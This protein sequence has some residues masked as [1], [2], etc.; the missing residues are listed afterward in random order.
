VN[1]ELKVLA[2]D[3]AVSFSEIMR[4]L[5][6]RLPHNSAKDTEAHHL[7]MLG[8]I[9]LCGLRLARELRARKDAH[10]YIWPLHGERFDS[11]LHVHVDDAEGGSRAERGRAREEA[12]EIIMF[13]LMC[14]VRVSRDG[15][16]SKM[17]TM[18]P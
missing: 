2:R 18:R 6:H 3:L 15:E 4:P 10:E 16:G 11:E 9:V 1:A 7:R 5:T 13:T 8:K 17:M 14:G 12:A